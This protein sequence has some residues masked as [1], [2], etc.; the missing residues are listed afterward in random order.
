MAQEQLSTA[1]TF[2]KRMGTFDYDGVRALVDQPKFVHHV[3][4]SS[5]GGF[6]H[7]Q[8][9]SI[10]EFIQFG[11]AR[12]KEFQ[13]LEFSEPHQTI[14]GTDQISL[15]FETTSTMVDGKVMKADQAFFFTFTPG[16]SKI[17][18]VVQF[19]DS[20]LWFKMAEQRGHPF[21]APKVFV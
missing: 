9:F 21:P 5:L 17:V 1:L 20:L 16:T 11:E 15:T 13:S 4:P 18:K 8:G 19:A 7:P 12:H 6:G 2:C 14:Q 3:R 10:E